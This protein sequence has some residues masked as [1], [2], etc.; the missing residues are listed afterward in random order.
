MICE[1]MTNRL[2]AHADGTLDLVERRRTR[3]HL[4]SCPRCAR[5]AAAIHDIENRVRMAFHDDPPAA[6]LWPRILDSIEAERVRRRLRTLGAGRRRFLRVSLA[7]VSVASLLLAMAL[8][9]RAGETRLAP[10]IWLVEAPVH[11]LRTFLVS[12]RPLDIGTDDPALLRRWFVGKVAFRPPVPVT[13]GAGLALVGGRLCYFLHRRA[14]SYVYRSGK[15]LLAF[16]VFPAAGL[17]L[18]AGGA[19]TGSGG[20]VSVHEVNGFTNVL[21]GDKG[22][23][24][25][26]VSDAPRARVLQT[27]QLLTRRD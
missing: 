17:G 21:W 18:P 20:R 9:I 5:E 2:Y 25:A 16:F 19:A 7:T 4:D 12:K 13:R 22:L 1:N 23:V 27:A 24:Y 14:V 6:G 3:C 11:D 10:P 8:Y 15:H 26:L